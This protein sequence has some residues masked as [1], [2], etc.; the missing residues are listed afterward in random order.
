MEQNGILASMRGTKYVT[1][2]AEVPGLISPWWNVWNFPK[3]VSYKNKNI[4]VQ[5]DW[6]L[7]Y[8]IHILC[9]NS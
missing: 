4:Y 9:L 3:V 6:K 2:P 8:I 7:S 5:S 1:T